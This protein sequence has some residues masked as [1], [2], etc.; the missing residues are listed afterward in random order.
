MKNVSQMDVE[1]NVNCP[2]CKGSGDNQH[3]QSVASY[4]LCCNGTGKLSKREFLAR[5]AMGQQILTQLDQYSI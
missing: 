2:V 1:G 4:C 3:T 5:Q